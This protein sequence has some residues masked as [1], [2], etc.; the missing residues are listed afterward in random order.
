VD[1][2]LAL[3]SKRLPDQMMF[4]PHRGFYNGPRIR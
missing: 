4:E 3:D 2:I 1:E